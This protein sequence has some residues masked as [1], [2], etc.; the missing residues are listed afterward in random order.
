MTVVAALED[1]LPSTSGIDGW[2][3]AGHDSAWRI[4]AERG[5]LDHVPRIETADVMQ[6]NARGLR[7]PYLDWIGALGVENDAVEWWA[8]EL[9]AR[10]SYTLLYDRVCSLATVLEITREHSDSTTLVVCPTAAFAAHLGGVA[11][12]HTLPK[13]SGAP[14]L[15]GWTRL[16]PR[17][18]HGLPGQMSER[19][20]LLLD[21]DPHYRRRILADHGALVRR[22]FTGTLL[23]TWI[24]A[25]S[26]DQDGTYS[27]PHFG[28]LAAMLRSRGLD[29]AFVPRVLPNFSYAEAVPRLLATGET[30]L[31]PDA[32]VEVDDQRDCARRAAAFSPAID[33][34]AAIAGVSVALLAREH[35][36]QYRSSQANALATD[37]L[38]RQFASSGV[39][40]ERIVHPCEGHGWE[41][42]LAWSARRHL[43]STSIVGYDNLNMSTLAL[44]MFPAR[45]EIGVRPLPDCIVTNGPAYRD[46]LVR[47]G[48]PDAIVRTGCALRHQYLW[49]AAPSRRPRADRLRILVATELALGPSVE[50]VDKAAQAFGG[51]NVELVVKAHP[52]LPR[53]EIV[54]VLGDRAASLRFDD[55]PSLELLGEVDVVLYTYSAV[56]YEALALGVPPVFVRSDS[57]VD[58][59]QLEY[60]RELRWEGRTP[61]D[62]RAAV[63]EIAALELDMWRERAS[64]AARAALAPPSATCVEAFL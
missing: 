25:R 14:L 39:I 63:E 47:E 2:L 51:G 22:P 37:A 1:R 43:P 13:R 27:D 52:L 9:A 45:A 44:S 12:D 6:R 40:P 8:S 53:D 11:G 49:E 42:V 17:P 32:Y 61:A 57:R 19:A 23:F 60:A 56:G 59:D 50:L 41:L 62:L 31:F 33:D 3:Y 28:P 16:A 24:D 21:S 30:F 46:V 34:A 18:L 7:T 58:L 26:F 15:R 4:A 5:R 20:R 54:G 48:V 64:A 10:T 35:I 36:E 38:I 29:V 55:R